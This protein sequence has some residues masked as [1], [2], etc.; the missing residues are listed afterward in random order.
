MSSSGLLNTGKTLAY[1]TVSR[2]GPQRWL[3]IEASHIQGEAEKA[4][5]T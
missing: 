3:R 5:T 1:W 2:E 4:A